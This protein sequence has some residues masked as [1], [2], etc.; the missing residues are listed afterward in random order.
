MLISQVHGLAFP[1]HPILPH[2]ANVAMQQTK[3]THR[4]LHVMCRKEK[5][6][7]KNRD[8]ETTKMASF[9]VRPVPTGIWWKIS[10]ASEHIYIYRRQTAKWFSPLR[11]L[12][13]I[14]FRPLFLIHTLLF[15]C[16]LTFDLLLSFLFDPFVVVHAV[17]ARLRYTETQF[18]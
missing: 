12:V 10:S 9:I 17:R 4:T 5:S 6:A 15:F 13:P 3:N 18:R 16:A 2:T 14:T 8:V 1:P 11:Y 7:S